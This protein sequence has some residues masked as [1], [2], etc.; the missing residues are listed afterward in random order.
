MALQRKNT[1]GG[2]YGFQK[3]SDALGLRY[4]G[5]IH[6]AHRINLKGEAMRKIRSS[7][8]KSTKFER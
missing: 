5:G 2:R 8:T 6:N 7:L 3:L 4:I 1:N